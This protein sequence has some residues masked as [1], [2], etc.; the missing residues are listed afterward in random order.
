MTK[1]ALTRA[2]LVAGMAA[3][4]A[5]LPAGAAEVSRDSYREAVEPICRSGTEANERILAGVRK[6]FN[7]GKLKPAATRFAKAAG[8]LRGTIA[9]LKAVP[10]PAA[11]RARL[12]KWLRFVGVEAKLF[13]RTA[14]KLR[15]ANKSGAQ[16]M[17]IRLEHQANLANNVAIPFEFQYCRFEPS[18]F[19]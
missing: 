7:Q 13:Q 3:L 15:A 5:A 16:A 11:D 2:A 17:V 19:T 8:A 10:R 9:R 14:A 6:Q 12:A 18:R 4:F 1:R